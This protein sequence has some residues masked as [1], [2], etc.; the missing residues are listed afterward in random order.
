LGAHGGTGL[1]SFG[2]ESFDASDEGLL[3]ASRQLFELLELASA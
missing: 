3:I 2:Q 1:L